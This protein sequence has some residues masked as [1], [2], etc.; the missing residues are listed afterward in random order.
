MPRVL[1]FRNPDI[2]QVQP[3]RE[4]IR[5]YCRTEGLVVLDLDLVLSSYAEGARQPVALV[6]L[7]F[8]KGG[9]FHYLTKGQEIVFGI[10]DKLLRAADPTGEYYKGFYILHYDNEDWENPRTRF[11]INGQ[12]IDHQQLVAFLQ[13]AWLPKPYQFPDP[14]TLRQQLSKASRRRRE[15]S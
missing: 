6:E 9:R 5:K 4:F 7:K 12:R 11:W 14:E 1:C 8:Y 3:H 13:L 2:F 10:L 15:R